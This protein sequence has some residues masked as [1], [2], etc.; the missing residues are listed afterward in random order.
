MSTVFDIGLKHIVMMGYIFSFTA[1]EFVNYF[2]VYD[3]LLVS[4]QALE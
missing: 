3:D 2:E 1:V 4:L